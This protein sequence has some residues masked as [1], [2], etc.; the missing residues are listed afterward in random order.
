[1]NG[2]RKKWRQKDQKGLDS[3]AS[4]Q[5]DDDRNGDDR[6]QNND[7]RILN[8]DHGDVLA[9]VDESHDE[10]L[11]KAD[12]SRDEVLAK[13]DDDHGRVLEKV[14][15]NRDEVLAKAEGDQGSQWSFS[16]IRI[17]SI[18]RMLFLAM[19]LACGTGVLLQASQDVPLISP[20]PMA[21]TTNSL[22]TSLS[23]WLNPMKWGLN[24]S[25]LGLVKQRGTLT[26][27]PLREAPSRSFAVMRDNFED[28]A[29]ERQAI[30]RTLMFLHAWDQLSAQARKEEQA[31]LQKKF[32]IRGELDSLQVRGT[33]I[34]QLIFRLREVE[35]KIKDDVGE[36]QLAFNDHLINQKKYFAARVRELELLINHQN[37]VLNGVEQ[38]ILKEKEQALMLDAQYKI[39]WQ[40]LVDKQHELGIVMR[41]SGRDLMDLQDN[42]EQL[43]REVVRLED[44]LTKIGNEREK[45]MLLVRKQSD[46][47]N[48]LLKQ[49]NNGMRMLNKVEQ[50]QDARQGRSFNQHIRSL[51]L[52]DVVAFDNVESEQEY[53]Q[54]D[55]QQR[56]PLLSPPPLAPSLSVP[57][58][59]QNTAFQE[60]IVAPLSAPPAPPIPQLHTSAPPAPPPPPVPSLSQE[61]GSVQ[62]KKV[63]VQQQKKEP[64][65][66]RAS[67]GDLLDQIRAG[68]QLKKIE[69]PEEGVKKESK[70]DNGLFGALSRA[71]VA[72]RN[73]VDSE[74]G[75]DNNNDDE[76]WDDEDESN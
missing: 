62:L 36:Y 56:A 63:S 61:V 16:V 24:D 25:A 59:Q 48:E 37:E 52:D 8:D 29:L 1:M 35:E 66:S 10:A 42:I 38:V 72:R 2:W 9:K 15:G 51:G 54:D 20:M 18:W 46:E 76:G 70:E 68:K 71:L 27:D 17:Q 14:D 43:G 26:E 23:S 44:E 30:K 31:R 50:I 64:K 53:Q 6:V 13:A 5:N 34:T 11:S 22:S 58:V 41:R 69:L 57:V 19:S 47:R 3:I 55:M 33:I 45:H 74:D 28:L 67:R 75:E 7:D 12:G 4:L 32:D 39:L 73:A 65:E 60:Q 40:Q 49:L 21:L